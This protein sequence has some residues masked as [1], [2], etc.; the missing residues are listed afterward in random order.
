[1]TLAF[2]ASDA[3]LLGTQ[4]ALVALPRP[5]A[6][7]W[8]QSLAA[9][10]RHRL[11]AAVPLA[12]IVG[13]IIAI[14]ATAASAE[15]LT[16]LAL[17][18]VPPLAFV[19]LGWV[20]HGSRW[21][22]ALLAAPLFA[23]AWIDHTHLWGEG[24]ALIL[25]ALSCVTLGVLITS[26]APVSWLKVGVV[27]MACAD[28]YLV[29]SSQLQAPNNVLNAAAPHVL[30][31]PQLQ[32]ELFGDA[33]MGYGDIFIAGV[34]GAL[35]AVERRPQLV[36]ALI[37][38]ALAAAFDVLFLWIDT[39]PATVPIAAALIVTEYLHRRRVRTASR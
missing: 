31:L 22:L 2:W 11:W 30:H 15:F 32:R 27:L 8:V 26:V 35:L 25:S 14:T 9:K 34:F 21:W 20:I 23:L 36:P 16:W 13:A 24:A 39:L 29:F 19:A 5:D 33:V 18:A 28:A 7:P 4:A 37:T 38:F 12:S 6:L 10:L 3:A 17:I 1:M